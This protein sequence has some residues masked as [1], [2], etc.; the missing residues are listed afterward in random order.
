MLVH[1]DRRSGKIEQLLAS[2]H[3]AVHVFDPRARLQVR[4]F[5]IAS[6]HHDDRIADDA[7]AA[8]RPNSRAGYAQVQPP[9]ERLQIG[10]KT[11]PTLPLTAG[12]HDAQARINFAVIVIQATSMDW[13]HL[14][15]T[16]HRRALFERTSDGRITGDWLAP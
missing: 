7:W 8:T 1:T 5:G 14:A 9:G 12:Q 11:G 16:G 3:V 6:V 4:I 2:P 15:A 10:L 13:L